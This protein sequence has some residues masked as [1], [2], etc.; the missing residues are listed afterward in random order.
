M[1]Q[2]T[3]DRLA[4]DTLARMAW[5]VLGD[6]KKV[7]IVVEPDFRDDLLAMAEKHP[8]WIVE[9][10]E[11]WPRIEA[12]WKLGEPMDLCY[13]NKYL[14]DD[15]T[16]R[17]QN[18]TDILDLVDLHHGKYAQGGGYDGLIVCGLASSAA[19]DE[20]LAA[21]GFRISEINEDSFVALGTLN[22]STY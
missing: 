7:A 9:T 14:V 17:K 12:A 18:L 20:N 22:E 21:L 13:I 10:P 16:D 11:N 15:P 6:D 2:Y 1:H 8:V 5:R 3:E 4:D 19:L